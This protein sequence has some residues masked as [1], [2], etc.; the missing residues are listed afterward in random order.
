[1]HPEESRTHYQV[2]FAVLATATIAYALLQSLVIPVLA[3]IQTGLHTS[4]NSV[5]WVLTAY[6]LSAS[7]F[8][9]IVGRLGDMFGKERMLVL[10]LVAL[11]AGCALAAVTDSLMVMI[12]AR[13]I[14][15]IGGGVLPLSFGLIRDEFPRERVAGAVGVIAALAAAGAGLGIVLAGPIVDALNFHWLFWIPMI[16]LVVSAVAAHVVVPESRVRTAGRVNW[17]AAVL[18][19]GWLVALMV[20]VSEA[21]TWGWGSG[22]VIGLIL[23]AVV[24]AIAWVMVEGHSAQPLIDMRMMRIP[25]VWTTNLVALLLGIGMYAAFAFLPQY[26]ETPT[27][28]GYGFGAG[29]THAGL[30]LLPSSVAM[31]IF[32][33][34]SGRASARL[35]ARMVLIIGTAV[36][37]VPF[38]LLT[39][40]RAHQWELVIAMALQGVGFGLAY[41]A[42]SNL[43][44]QAVPAEQTGV[45]SGMNAN[46]RTI[47]GSLGAAVMSSIVTATAHHGGLP[48]DA[49]YTHGFLALTL[50]AAAAAAASL[51]VPRLRGLRPVASGPDTMPHAELALLAG[52]TV[53]GD[54][55]E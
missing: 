27:S 32:G 34:L 42:M 11:A 1:M 26:L 28:A 19:S 39:V 52:G 7:I 46:I 23:A 48:R 33:S 40:A 36:G 12:V 21:P 49:G 51:L 30:I 3:T 4:Q 9:P 44:V 50:A 45:A 10:A 2:T 31:F 15:G 18:L 37:I 13:V 6:L 14:Q 17:L 47:G 22:K 8:T 55:P 5:T 41:A 53:A 35:G 20:A 25:T 29:I 16:I 24:L 43:V 38:V 54:Q